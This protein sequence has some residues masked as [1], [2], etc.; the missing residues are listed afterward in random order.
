MKA[1]KRNL[2][3]ISPGANV[4]LN[5]MFIFYTCVCILP[6][7][8]VLGIS[9]SDEKSIL[10]HG[11]KLIPRQFSLQGYRYLFSDA[12]GLL[13]N[14]AITIGATL[15]GTF[16]TVTITA[17]FAYPLSRKDF[18]YRNILSFI[19]FFTMIFHGGLVPT[20]M[21]Y[22]QLLSL[23]NNLAVYIVPHLMSAWY[24][25]I[26]RTFLSQSLPDSVTEAAKIDGAKERQ[27][28][29]RI[30]LPLA[31][32][33]LATIALFTS[34]RIWNDWYT[35]LLYVTKQKLFNLQYSMHLALLNAEFLR[36]NPDV[37]NEL[38]DAQLLESM[39]TETVRMAM[40][41]V[42]IGPIIMAY[43]FFQKYFVKGLTIGAVKG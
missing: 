41:I 11:F 43:P 30:V 13:R 33:G 9:L 19:V 34:I 12:T 31:R 42:A 39:P 8:L 27:I 22:A 7:L 14:Y 36:Q 1:S 29:V 10:D 32:P 25:I 6:F 18:K 35:P 3:S 16:L 38:G 23:R 5:L 24:V 20:Y 37:L 28:F 2:T 26:M 17:L 40:C 4:V 21:I 15:V